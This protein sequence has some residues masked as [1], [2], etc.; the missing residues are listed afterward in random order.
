MNKK[1]KPKKPTITHNGVIKHPPA[2]TE[3][4]VCFSFKNLQLDHKRFNLRSVGKNYLPKLVARL[5][6]ISGMPMKE[7][8][9]SDSPTLRMNRIY[10]DKASENG[11]GIPN[12]KE[13]D[14][15]PW[16]FSITRSSHGRVHGYIVDNIFYIRWLDPDHKLFPWK[17]R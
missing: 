14:D 4:K 17:K 3:K 10:W 7:L 15:E 12:G 11:F 16:E 2:P 9:L 8:C 6:D 1:R 5:K 13:L